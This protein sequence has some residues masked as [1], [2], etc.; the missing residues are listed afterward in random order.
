MAARAH[1]PYQALARLMHEA[2]EAL[3][4]VLHAGVGR[5]AR[6][7]PA[8]DAVIGLVDTDVLRAETSHS[9]EMLASGAD[10]RHSQ[11]ASLIPYVSLQAPNLLADKLDL[12][13][14]LQVNRG[15]YYEWWP[16]RDAVDPDVREQRVSLAG[17]DDA[18]TALHAR[19]CLLQTCDAGLPRLIA[20]LRVRGALPWAAELRSVAWDYEDGNLIRL[21]PAGTY[22][23]Q[24]PDEFLR[25]YCRAGVDQPIPHP[26][27]KLPGLSLAGPPDSADL[28]PA[29][30][31]GATAC[32][33]SCCTCR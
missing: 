14:D 1:W 19:G 24:F 3:P 4:S 12:L 30:A 11:A 17:S 15:A 2:P 21:A 16:W 31:P 28:R 25:P 32:C 33:T 5:L 7:S 26:T 9:I 10:P 27:W 13:G 18:G 23:V 8:V 6:S 29:G 20:A 22:H